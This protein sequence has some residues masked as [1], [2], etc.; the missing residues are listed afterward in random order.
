M[1]TRHIITL[2]LLMAFV[3]GTATAQDVK[4]PKHTKFAIGIHTGLDIGAA[5]PYPLDGMGEM[6]INAVPY[7]RPQL[8]LSAEYRFTKRWSVIAEATYKKLG[9]EAEARVQDQRFNDESLNGEVSFNGVANILMSFAML[10]VPVMATYTFKN[11]NRLYVGAYYSWVFK[12]Q[13][14]IVAAKGLVSK[15]DNPDGDPPTIVTPDSPYTQSFSDSLDNWDAGVLLGY[16]FRI[17]PIERLTIGARLSMG[18]K[19]IF[20][21]NSTGLNFS[22]L[23]MRG[24]V[25]LGFDIFRFN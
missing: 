14:D 1:K 23:H 20:K 18:F 16:D 13:F 15:V 10:E 6:K 12:P 21:P 4:K 25:V 22:M 7:L 8:G 9:I 24:S 2:A 5:A 19:D 3:A 17:R 11:R